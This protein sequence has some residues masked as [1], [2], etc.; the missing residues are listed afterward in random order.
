MKNPV[1]S[2]RNVQV[3]AEET[4]VTV[5]RL[6]MKALNPELYHYI[7]QHVATADA[8]VCTNRHGD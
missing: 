8:P 5:N 4:D 1:Y 2:Q 6:I 7:W 3:A